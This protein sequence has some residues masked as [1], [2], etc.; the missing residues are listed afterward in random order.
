M[1]I[2][3][4]HFSLTFACQTTIFSSLGTLLQMKRKHWMDYSATRR[5]LLMV[6]LALH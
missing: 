5:E 1:T 3:M 6:R 2:H 4:S